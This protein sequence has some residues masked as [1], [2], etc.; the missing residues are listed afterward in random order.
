MALASAVCAF[1]VSSI[2][3]AV[4]HRH[5]AQLMNRARLAG[6]RGEPVFGGDVAFGPLGGRR[7]S[8]RGAHAGMEARFG[9]HRG[10]MEFL[11]AENLRRE[12]GEGLGFLGYAR[13]H[14]LG[15]LVRLK[16]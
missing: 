16:T 10:L 13:R 12:L 5:L 6:E 14:F 7:G 2:L 1:L 11:G 9:F 4:D 15:Q 8:G 3:L